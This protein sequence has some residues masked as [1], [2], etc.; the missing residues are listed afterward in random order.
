MT[1]QAARFAD[2]A[3]SSAPQRP[4]DHA[5]CLQFR[6]IV[7][8]WSAHSVTRRGREIQLS[9][10]EFRLMAFFMQNA[11]RTLSRQ[12]LFDSVWASPASLPG[13]TVDVHVCRLRRALTRHGGRGP[14][15]TVR[16]AGYALGNNTSSVRVVPSPLN[17]HENFLE[18]QQLQESWLFSSEHTRGL[19]SHRKRARAESDLTRSASKP[20][21]LGEI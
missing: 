21:G 18:R 13:R 20:E 16:G 3:Q 15:R 7:L 11:G 2:G 10:T 19:T 6:D 17:R 12:E 9:I 1:W 4:V 5:E 14:I 8:D